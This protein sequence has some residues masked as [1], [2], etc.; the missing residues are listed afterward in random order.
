MANV[1]EF[2]QQSLPGRICDCSLLAAGFL[3]SIASQSGSSRSSSNQSEISEKG[4]DL[5][6]ALNATTHALRFRK[7]LQSSSQQILMNSKAD[8]RQWPAKVADCLWAIY[9]HPAL[10]A[11]PSGERM[12]GRV[13]QHIY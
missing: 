5:Y 9:F 1:L 12:A 2:S 7:R 4:E 11:S 6:F 13:V 10:E 3:A 8:Q